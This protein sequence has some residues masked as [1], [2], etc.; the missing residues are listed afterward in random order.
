MKKKTEKIRTQPAKWNKNKRTE[1]DRIS[2]LSYYFFPVV[3]T[4]Y[5]RNAP[6]DQE[7]DF[8]RRVHTVQRHIFNSCILS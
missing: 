7:V 3:S 1:C 6:T 4:S 8:I 5:N 2:V